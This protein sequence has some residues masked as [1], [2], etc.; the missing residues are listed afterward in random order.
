[1]SFSSSSSSSCSV[2]SHPSSAVSSSARPSRPASEEND[3]FPYVIAIRSYRRAHAIK[4]YTIGWLEQQGI[5][6]S[7]IVLFVKQREMDEYRAALGDDYRYVDQGAEGLCL[8]NK[9]VQ[10]YFADGE[11]VVLMDD[12]ILRVIGQD[13]KPTAL[14]PILRA[15]WN[16]MQSTRFRAWGLYPTPNPYFMKKDVTYGLRFLIGNL[17]GFINDRQ[18]PMPTNECR[19]DYERTIL[20]YERYGGVVRFDKWST[21]AKLFSG[22]GGNVDMRT[23]DKMEQSCADLLARYPQYVRRKK[24]KSKY[25]EIR[26]LSLAPT[27]PLSAAVAVSEKQETMHPVADRKDSEEDAVRSL[28]STNPQERRESVVNVVANVVVADG[29]GKEPGKEQEKG[30]SLKKRRAEHSGK[31][32]GEERGE[33]E[34]RPRIAKRSKK[35]IK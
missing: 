25:S 22:K 5:P 1:M 23:A 34:A 14:L 31:E 21:V 19:E 6:R 32:C 29:K 2:V 4:K 3:E 7:K 33:G 13:R 28:A 12:D 9:K 20:H 35:T 16:E 17:V 24:C 30:T 11:H 10:E 18:M 15:G 8:C 27:N 26:L